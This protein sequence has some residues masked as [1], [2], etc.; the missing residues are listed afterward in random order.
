MGD[1]P[2]KLPPLPKRTVLRVAGASDLKTPSHGIATPE[3]VKAKVAEAESQLTIAAAVK[4]RLATWIG[5]GV[6]SAVTLGGVAIAYDKLEAKAAD[7]GS[8][9]AEVKMA[10]VVEAVKGHEAR[11]Q[12][13]E[14]TSKQT[15]GDVHEAR[16]ELRDLYKAV[17]EGKRSER[18]ER[19]VPPLDGGHP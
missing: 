15:Q 7:A 5:A 16:G 6:L 1:E 8:S 19:P 10:P 12:V 13:L 2:P 9:A 4:A 17:M 14:Q 11:L 3:Y 18:L